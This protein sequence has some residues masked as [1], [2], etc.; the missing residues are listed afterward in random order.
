MTHKVMD[1][2]ATTVNIDSVNNI[3]D[4]LAFIMVDNPAFV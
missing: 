1:T 2:D 4:N 3:V